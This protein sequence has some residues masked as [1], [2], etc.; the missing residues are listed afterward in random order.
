LG[1]TTSEKL[2]R[3]FRRAG[4]QRSNLAIQVVELPVPERAGAIC[5]LLASALRYDFDSQILKLKRYF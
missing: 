2:R 5:G 1:H 3:K 4:F